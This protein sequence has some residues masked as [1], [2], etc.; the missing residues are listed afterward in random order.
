TRR[1]SD[2]SVFGQELYIFV[3]KLNLCMVFLLVFYVFLYPFHHRLANRISRL[4]TLPRKMLI[5]LAFGF[6]PTTAVALDFFYKFCQSNVFRHCCQN[7]NM[8]FRSVDFYRDRTVFLY[9]TSDIRIQFR[10]NFGSD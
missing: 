3:P 1:S 8:V 5:F 10:L 7:M 6:Y 4:S 9:Y 2:L